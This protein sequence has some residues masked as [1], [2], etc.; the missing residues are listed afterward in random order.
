MRT[1]LAIGLA[2]GLFLLPNVDSKWIFLP[3]VLAASLLPDIDS[4]FSRL[5]RKG[6]FRIL[7]WFVKHRGVIHSLT[8]AFVISI[9]FAFFAP[10]LALPF[11]L[12]YSFHL[13]VDGFTPEGVRPFWPFKSD[14]KGRFKT[15]GRIEDM[16]FVVFLLIDVLLLI[17]LFV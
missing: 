7:Q 2:V 14:V 12:G 8:F 6:I 16:I 4:G 1:H 3:V 13:L 15:G 17:G 11:F 5:G 10:V 9:V